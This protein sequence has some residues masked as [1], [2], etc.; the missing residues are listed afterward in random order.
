MAAAACMR[1]WNPR[2]RACC[3]AKQA[4]VGSMTLLDH[5]PYQARVA[6]ELQSATGAAEALMAE[7][8]ARVTGREARLTQMMEDQ[9]RQVRAAAVAE[10]REAAHA[11]AHA[12]DAHAHA[13]AHAH[14]TCTCTCD[15]RIHA[16]AHAHA[17][18]H[19]RV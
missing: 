19:M 5:H 7:R 2:V 18:C 17:T 4:R 8:E 15:M 14:A 16:H 3:P 9:E 13:H 1:A 12:H 10:G 6:T 11:H